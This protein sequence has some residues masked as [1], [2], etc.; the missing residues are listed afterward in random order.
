MSNEQDF[1]SSIT[2]RLKMDCH[3]PLPNIDAL[4]F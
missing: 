4:E 3:K 2:K 1:K